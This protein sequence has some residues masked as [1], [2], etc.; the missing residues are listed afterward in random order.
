MTCV[1]DDLW[2]DEHTG[3]LSAIEPHHTGPLTFGHRDSTLNRLCLF[4]DDMIDI[5][6]RGAAHVDKNDPPASKL[7]HS[8]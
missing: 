4:K 1:Q 7:S 5:I 8:S 6:T 3:A 2:F